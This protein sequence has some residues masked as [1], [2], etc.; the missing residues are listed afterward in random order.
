[1]SAAALLAGLSAALVVLA[2]RDAARALG[3]RRRARGAARRLRA[4]PRRQGARGLGRRLGVPAAPRDLTARIAAAGEPAGLGTEDVMALKCVAAAGAV[5]LALAAASALPGRLGVAVLVA[6]PAAGF[7]VP[8]VLL[9]RRG[10]RRGAAARA[11]APDVLDRL[12]LAVE[13]GLPPRRAVG[14]AGRHGS[15]PFAEE[16]RAVAA[17][18]ELGVARETA[19]ERLRTRCPTPEAAALAAALARSERLGAPLAPEVGRLAQTARA[20]RARRLH[21]RAQRAAPKIQLVVA[22][23]LVP[24]AMLLLAAGM[25]AGL[26]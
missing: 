17:A 8:D 11:E 5:L 19:L 7:L 10:R 25:L 22:L 4:H 24:A 3:T 23:L 15:G 13:A 1:M 16:L 26:R 9:A 21:D 6:A 14:E 12:R 2:A 20:E 18:V